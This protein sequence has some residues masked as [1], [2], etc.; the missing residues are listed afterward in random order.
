MTFQSLFISATTH[1]TFGASSGAFSN[2]PTRD[3]RW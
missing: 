1:P 3:P 2:L